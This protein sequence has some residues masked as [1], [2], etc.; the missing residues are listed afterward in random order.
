[1]SQKE[2][3]QKKLE[4]EYIETQP[5]NNPKTSDYYT[6]RDVPERFDKPET[7]P[8]SHH[9]VGNPVFSCPTTVDASVPP[10]GP[11]QDMFKGYGMKQPHPMYM[12]SAMEYGNRKPTVHVMPQT[13]HA[14]SQK[15]SEH[16]GQCGMYRNYSLNTSV[17]KNPVSSQ[18]DGIF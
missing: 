13:F 7:L 9:N 15:F 10:L 14:K 6:V 4:Q 1:M 11:E 3:L 17:D 16:L 8:E 5:G 18:F 2:K 12:T